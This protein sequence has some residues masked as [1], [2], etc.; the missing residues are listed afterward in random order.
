MKL[1]FKGNYENEK[2][3]PKGVLPLNAVEFSEPQNPR[4][5]NR[6]A[7]LFAVLLIALLMF[8]S[9]LL[10]GSIALRLYITD[11]WTILD[12]WIALLLSLVALYPHELLHAVC[13]GK[14]ANVELFFAPK[15][16]MLFVAS[17]QPITKS[18]FILLSLLPNLIFGWL[19]LLV[20]AALPYG[21]YSNI[22][23]LFS[24]FSI[25]LGIGDYSNA[26][27]ALHQMPK[28][29]I[30]QMSGSHSYWFIP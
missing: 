24:V 23:F 30:Q 7:L 13:F 18:R 6:I 26:Y 27:S 19:P 2:Q 9:S 5:L 16:L 11:L 14:H 4:Q 12:L 20:W 22:L 17:P 8:I 3:L 21:G 10:H 29:S 25:L 15:K 28:G 1:V